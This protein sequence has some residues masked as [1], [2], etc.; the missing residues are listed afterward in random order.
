MNTE[1]ISVISQSISTAVINILFF[2]FYKNIYGT[3][4]NNKFIYIASYIL[5]VGLMIWINQLE[6]QYINLVYSYLSLN[7]VCVL[8]F[9]TGI[10]KM[11][12]YNTLLW[13]FLVCCDAVTVL[14]WSAIGNN[15]L[16]EVLDNYQLMLA[17]NLINIL[18]M[19][20][21]WKIYI[22]VI[23]KFNIKA[24]N[25][26][27]TLFMAVLAFFEIF[28]IVSFAQ[29]INSRSGGV[30]VIG[31]TAG[32]IFI[33]VFLSYIITQVSEAYQYKYE[34]SMVKQLQEVQLENYKEI[35]QK[36]KESRV[37][38][39]DIKKHLMVIED[40][41]G[42]E[43]EKAKEYSDHVYSQM[44]KLFCGFHCSNQILSIIF[45]QKISKAKSEGVA[46]QTVVDDVSLDF[47]DDL[48]I[49]AIFANLWDN[50]IE[51]CRKVE[52][53]KY[54]YIKISRLN[55]LILIDF[56]NSF[57]GELL[58]VKKTFASTKQAHEGV[59]LKIIND[60]V[61][62]YGG[63]YMTDVEGLI[64]KTEITL[65]TPENK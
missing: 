36:Y 65:P 8:L 48:D 42:V 6:N 19:C 17:S 33:N 40:L 45:S 3:K 12:L 28:I 57:N 62:K 25:W 31:I 51:A 9:D 52:T 55:S 13:L 27:L 59:G 53:N 44:D 34:L 63:I 37:I 1:I 14:I 7:I 32:L 5:S 10:K 49:T 50:A 26:K 22:T 30:K 47:M 64:F 21:V 24:I 38:I 23:Q 41:K 11:W 20:I 46:V 39:H 29:E 16:V 61:D 4:Y 18:L 58:P 43:T 15:T 35:E 2:L 54:I 60:S 56:K